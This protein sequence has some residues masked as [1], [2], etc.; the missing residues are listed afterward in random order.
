MDLVVGVTGASGT[1]YAVKLLEALKSMENVTTHVIFSEYAWMNLEIETD[2]K[3]ADIMNMSDILYDNRDLAAPVASG[4]YPVDG[5]IVL[6][7]SM[8]TLASVSMGLC[9]NLISR[10]CDVAM[11]EQRKLVI[12]P[13]E[14][15]LNAIHLENMLKLSRLGAAIVP[16]M[17]GFYSRPETVEEIINHHIMKVLDQFGLNY[18]KG[19]RWKA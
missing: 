16:P 18:D 19:K 8:K 2:F 15:P 14:T 6:P 9:D 3:K 7:C 4:S 13:R 17:P 1:I 12:C 11:K 5:V 10:V